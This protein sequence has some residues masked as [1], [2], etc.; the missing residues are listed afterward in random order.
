MRYNTYIGAHEC[1][2]SRLVIGRKPQ[3]GALGKDGRHE[4]AAQHGDAPEVAVAVKTGR[5]RDTEIDETVGADEAVPHP[6]R[7]PGILQK[8]QQR[9]K[10]QRL[11]NGEGQ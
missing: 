9:I 3:V 10:Q 5:D 1:D 4:Q 8:G 11:D 7:R 6:R 2:R